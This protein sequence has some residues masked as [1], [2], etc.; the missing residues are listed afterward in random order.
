M[1]PFAVSDLA[2]LDVGVKIKKVGPGQP[3]HH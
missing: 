3:L 2:G 1:G